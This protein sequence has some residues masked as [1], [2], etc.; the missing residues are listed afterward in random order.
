MSL[1][2]LSGTNGSVRES[3]FCYNV[4]DCIKNVNAHMTVTSANDN[5]AINLWVDDDG[6]YRGE[7]LRYCITQSFVVCKTKKELRKW[8]SVEFNKI[9]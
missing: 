9:R 5:G 4:T 1:S 6:K 3:M 2:G 8:L 7:R